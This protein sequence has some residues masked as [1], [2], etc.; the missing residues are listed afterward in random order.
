MLRHDF[1]KP[2]WLSIS[3]KRLSNLIVLIQSTL[4]NFAN[5]NADVKNERWLPHPSPVTCLEATPGQ[6][7]PDEGICYFVCVDDAGIFH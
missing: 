7:D 3:Q 2:V 1:R 5:K 6:I 4:P